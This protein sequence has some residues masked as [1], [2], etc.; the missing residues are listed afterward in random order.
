AILRG[1]KERYA[2]HH[3]MTIAD[4]AIV[5][6]ALLSH[7]YITDR[8]LPAKG[9]DFIG[10]AGSRIRMEIDSMP[11]EMD[12]L[13]RRII[14]LKMEREALSKEKDKASQERLEKVNDEIAELEK[15]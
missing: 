9:S 1:M 12:R 8:Q 2:L 4:G 15:E 5:A 10:E 14:Q 3:G 7:R 6:A 13:D 11:E